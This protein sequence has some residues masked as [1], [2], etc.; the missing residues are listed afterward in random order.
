MPGMTM[1][2]QKEVFLTC[3]R[4]YAG[5]RRSAEG[6]AW[7]GMRAFEVQSRR[8]KGRLKSSMEVGWHEHVDFVYRLDAR[9][10]WLIL[11]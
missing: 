10:I 6:R 11:R 9:S 8:E 2:I 5:G 4:V 3:D 1:A 7:S